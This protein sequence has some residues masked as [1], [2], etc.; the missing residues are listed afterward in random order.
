M[1]V[2]ICSLLAASA[3][4]FGQSR[5][6]LPE[7]ATQVS[8]HVW[9]IAGSPNIGIVVGTRAT[10]VVDTGLG[11]RNGET[12]VRVAAKLSNNPNQKLFL[13]TTHFHPEHAAGEPGF[14]AGTVLIRNTAQQR[15]MEKEGEG[16]MTA[17][18][19]MSDLNKELLAGVQ[20]RTPDVLFENDATLDLGGG[21][22]A[23]LF[24]LGAAHT[25]GDEMILVEPDKTLISGDIVQNKTV[26]AMQPN[27]GSPKSWSAVLDK[28]AALDV[29]HVLPDHSAP[30]DGSMVA[31]ERSF[32]NA[33]R[34]RALA[35]KAQGV[36]VEDAAKQIVSEFQPKY[37]DWPNM[38]RAGDFLKRIY[39]GPE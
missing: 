5:S 34:D 27:C 33:L 7:T 8:E 13:T 25:D 12:I 4:A 26:P 32:F 38:N 14:P 11:P 9:M 37:P 35:L 15:E 17:F 1:R 20:L 36:P 24:W 16:M 10:L 39:S 22:T 28:V 18:R 6:I 30:G 21:V 23:R 19:G 31:A 29:R 3:C 2:L